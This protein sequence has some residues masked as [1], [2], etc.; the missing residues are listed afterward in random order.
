MCGRTAV[1]V[2]GDCCRIAVIALTT[3]TVAAP[4]DPGAS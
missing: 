2:P 4:A 1:I 3:V